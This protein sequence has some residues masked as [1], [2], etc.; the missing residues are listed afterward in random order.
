[1]NAWLFRTPWWGQTL[2]GGLIFGALQVVLRLGDR[3]WV[4]AV[5]AGLLGG[6]LFGLLLAPFLAARNRRVRDAL[7]T[8][9]PDLFRAATLGARG[10]A[11]PADP[12]VRE[13]AHRLALLQRD[14]LLRQR[15]RGAA[16]FLVLVVV[17]GGLAVLVSSVFWFIAAVAAV[18]L[19]AYLLMPSRLERRAQLLA[20]PADTAS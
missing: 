6:A 1:M 15:R 5:V 3:S 9:D 16:V 18:F 11:L 10:G 17:S 2:V 7:G 12:S 8:D 20:G 19:A 4:E 14:E 13:A